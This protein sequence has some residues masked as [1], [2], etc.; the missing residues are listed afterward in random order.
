MPSQGPMCSWH[1]SKVDSGHMARLSLSQHSPSQVPSSH[2]ASTPAEGQG[3]LAW[4]LQAASADPGEREVGG[5]PCWV[6]SLGRRS[7]AQLEAPC[8]RRAP[9]SP[10]QKRPHPP[11]TLPPS[12]HLTEPSHLLLIS[13]PSNLISSLNAVPLF[14]PC[15]NPPHL[16]VSALTSCQLNTPFTVVS[17]A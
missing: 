12:V 1:G 6:R 16:H 4:H 7:R 11:S 3:Q 10:C 8:S 13:S 15:A 9:S 14:F 2:P 17:H 5:C